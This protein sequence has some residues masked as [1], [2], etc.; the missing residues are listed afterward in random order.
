MM[1]SSVVAFFVLMAS[2]VVAFFVLM[3]S[4]V[5][6]FFVLMASSVVAFFVL[7]AWLHTHRALNSEPAKQLQGIII[8]LFTLYSAGDLLPDEEGLDPSGIMKTSGIDIVGMLWPNIVVAVVLISMCRRTIT[9]N[10]FVVAGIAISIACSFLILYVL[11]FFFCPDPNEPIASCGIS[12][13]PVL[14]T[15]RPTAV[16]ILACLACSIPEVCF[17]FARATY[18]PPEWV[19]LNAV[20]KKVGLSAMRQHRNVWAVPAEVAVETGGGLQEQPEQGVDTG[21]TVGGAIS[22]KPAVEPEPV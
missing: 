20:E 14:L 5:V 18:T 1:T 11:D 3:A 16:G 21:A 7:M 22:L 6:A 9:W 12:L 15:L 10:W 13:V 17:T 4:S 2:S 8:I 19:K